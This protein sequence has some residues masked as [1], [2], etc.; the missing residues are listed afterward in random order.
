M[1]VQSHHTHTTHMALGKLMLQ[2]TPSYYC[3]VTQSIMKSIKLSTR[4][5]SETD[6]TF[7]KKSASQD[8]SLHTTPRL[9]KSCTGICI[10]EFVVNKISITTRRREF[11]FG[12]DYLTKSRKINSE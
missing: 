2:R 8:D 6:S 12:F 4:L 3:T 7:S 1:R 11:E 10:A 9:G 5:H